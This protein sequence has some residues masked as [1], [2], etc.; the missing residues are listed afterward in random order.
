M[1]FPLN[2]LQQVN[3]KEADERLKI[4]RAWVRAHGGFES[5]QHAATQA[6]AEYQANLHGLT[7]YDYMNGKV[8]GVR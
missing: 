7:L 6:V 3:A 1:K 2:P 5:S 4:A 8:L